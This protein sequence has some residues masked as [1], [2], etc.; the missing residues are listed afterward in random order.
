MYCIQKIKRSGLSPS[1]PTFFISEQYT[2]GS[3]AGLGKKSH[4]NKSY[5]SWHAVYF[6]LF[7]VVI[8]LVYGILVG[9]VMLSGVNNHLS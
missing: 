6:T 3:K 5:S 2:P 4:K 1:V 8:L 7:L 9:D